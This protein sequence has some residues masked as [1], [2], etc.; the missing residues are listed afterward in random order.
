MP[1]FE[2]SPN[3]MPLR[4]AVHAMQFKK[5]YKGNRHDLNYAWKTDPDLIDTLSFKDL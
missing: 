5:E 2:H 4:C 3:R 1:F